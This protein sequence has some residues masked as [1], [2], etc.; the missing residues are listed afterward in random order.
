VEADEI[1]VLDHG[2]VIE[3]GSHR[4]LLALGGR[5]TQMWLLQQAGQDTE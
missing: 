4:E 1:L 5:Y 2:R 3:H